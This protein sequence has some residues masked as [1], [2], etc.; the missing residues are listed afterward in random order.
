[1]F[2]SGDRGISVLLRTSAPVFKIKLI[3][4]FWYFDPENILIDNKS[5]F[6]QA[7][8]T[9]ISA[10]K[11]ALVRTHLHVWTL[12]GGHS[13]MG[14]CR[15]VGSTGLPRTFSKGSSA[16]LHLSFNGC[17]WGGCHSFLHLGSHVVY[18]GLDR[19]SCFCGVALGVELVEH[20]YCERVWAVKNDSRKEHGCSNTTCNSANHTS[21]S[22]CR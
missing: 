19:H 3:I 22:E 12:A 20:S 15:A 17:C 4:F 14:V 5:Y 21:T 10:K 18:G 11:E 1:M 2:G 9:G 7:G 16:V 6:F 8:L 13:I